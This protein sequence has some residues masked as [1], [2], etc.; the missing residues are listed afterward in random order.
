M[1]AKSGPTVNIPNKVLPFVFANLRHCDLKA[2]RLVCRLW[3]IIAITNLFKCIYLSFRPKDLEVFRLIASH[4]LYRKVVR[5][6]IFDGSKAV[7]KGSTWSKFRY[8]EELMTQWYRLRQSNDFDATRLK[9]IQT[10]PLGKYLQYADKLIMPREL[11][12]DLESENEIIQGYDAYR[13]LVKQEQKIIESGTLEAMLGPGL[14]MLSNFKEA[15]ICGKMLFESPFCRSWPLTYLFPIRGFEEEKSDRMDHYK[16]PTEGFQHAH[17][18]LMR[19][20]T[21]SRREIQTLVIDRGREYQKNLIA[22]DFFNREYWKHSGMNTISCIQTTYSNLK[23]LNLV[24]SSLS[25]PEDYETANWVRLKM[26]ELINLALSFELME[27][28]G[29]CRYLYMSFDFIRSWSFPR[30]R[31]V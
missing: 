20:L 31:R 10:S 6:L 23:T 22:A 16:N 29:E 19:A 28:E 14:R 7:E 9:A 18:Y 17:N 15:V 24:L 3:S 27:F 26:H 30:L 4:E 13:K 1:T 2:V 21:T 25:A 8:C 11:A 5:T 12:R